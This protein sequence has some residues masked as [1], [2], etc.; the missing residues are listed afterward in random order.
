MEI[1]LKHGSIIGNDKLHINDDIKTNNYMLKFL[2]IVT[3]LSFAVS[4]FN[5]YINVSKPLILFFIE[6]YV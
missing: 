1:L 4:G 2:Y 5:A 6:L 3:G